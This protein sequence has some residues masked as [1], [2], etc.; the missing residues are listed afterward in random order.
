MCRLIEINRKK[1]CE[2]NNKDI[3]VQKYL[4][5]K[6]LCKFSLVPDYIKKSLDRVVANINYLPI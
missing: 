1:R 5:R 6:G 2:K 4:Y 3:R